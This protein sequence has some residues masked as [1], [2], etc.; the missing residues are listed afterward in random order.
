MKSGD[1]LALDR[2][3]D[4]GIGIGGRQ[5]VDLREQLGSGRERAAHARHAT[6]H[7]TAAATEPHRGRVRGTDAVCNLRVAQL[8][9]REPTPGHG[10]HAVDLIVEIRVVGDR[11]GRVDA[12]RVLA[13][14]GKQHAV[15]AAPPPQLGV[16]SGVDHRTR[17]D[18]DDAIRESQRGPAVRD[19]DR[20]A[21]AGDAAQGR[22]D[23]LFDPS[24]DRRRCVVEQQD[25]GIGEQR[26]R[27]RDALPLTTRQRQALFADHG[28]VAVRQAHDEVV[29]LRGAGRRLHV[30]RGRV[31]AAE[32][33]VR[34]DRVGEQER[35]LEHHADVAAQGLEGDATNIAAVDGNAAVVHVVEAREEQADGRLSRARAA[36]ERDRFAGCDR[37]REVTENRF[38]LRVAEGD[39][40]EAHLARADDELGGIRTILHDRRGVEEVEDALGPRACELTDREDRGEHPHRG[41]ELQHVRREREER[42]EADVVVQRQPAAEREHRDLTERRDRL[43][44]GLEARGEV[45][46]PHPRRVHVAGPGREAIQLA[47]LLAEALDDAHSGDVFLHHVRDVACLLLRIPARGKHGRA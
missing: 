43:H 24:V 28:V 35:V 1:G 9:D 30:C 3:V 13:R 7:R 47:G 21:P 34:R 22:V 17:I 18:D 19:E 10:R 37:E 40:V 46:Q 33:N 2:D 11:R 23:L 6:S 38:G 36:D 45:H 42:P 29:G 20:R 41:R 12:L 16:R 26:P 15:Q 44:G 39:V 5:R 25:A 27:E 14:T 4:V 31:V 32:R 8:V